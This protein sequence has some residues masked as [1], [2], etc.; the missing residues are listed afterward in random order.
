MTIAIHFHSK[1]HSIKKTSRV[2]YHEK[3]DALE[4]LRRCCQINFLLS[5]THMTRR[6]SPLLDLASIKYTLAPNGQISVMFSLFLLSNS[7]VRTVQR[8]KARPNQQ[9]TT[10]LCSPPPFDVNRELHSATH[11]YNPPLHGY[12]SSKR[13]M[14]FF[15]A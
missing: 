4:N 11:L 12:P 5:A 13:H 8:N 1:Q 6:I 10:Y 2:L 7:T 15:A 3:Y 9:Y 14:S